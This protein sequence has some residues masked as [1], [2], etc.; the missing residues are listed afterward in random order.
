MVVSQRPF[1]AT[2]RQLA[3]SGVYRR[4][5]TPGLTRQGERREHHGFAI[6]GDLDPAED[7]RD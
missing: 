2:A 4:T 1:P 5:Q 3:R 7:I 6:A